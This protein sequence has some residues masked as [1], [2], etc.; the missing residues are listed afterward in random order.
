M[1]NILNL[2]TLV[3]CV[4]ISFSADVAAQESRFS[5]ILESEV[6]ALEQATMIAVLEKCGR[7]DQLTKII[8]RF[9]TVDSD[10]VLALGHMLIALPKLRASLNDPANA[11][12]AAAICGSAQ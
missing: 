9:E 10:A 11:D 4:L 3:A 7:K 12:I 6:E 8:E 2:T 5:F 1:K